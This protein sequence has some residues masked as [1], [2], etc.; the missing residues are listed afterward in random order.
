MLAM[1]VLRHSQRVCRLVIL[2]ERS[3]EVLALNS[4]FHS[5][6]SRGG[7]LINL[8]LSFMARCTVL[9]YFE[10]EQGGSQEQPYFLL[11]MSPIG[12]PE[13]CASCIRK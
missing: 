6:L 12:T 1:I 7:M 3:A 9:P 11:A 2:L 5:S 4:V 13:E 8:G 10:S